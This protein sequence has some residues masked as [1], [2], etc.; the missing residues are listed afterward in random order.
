M[1]LFVSSAFAIVIVTL[2][3]PVNGRTFVGLAVPVPLCVAFT[4]SFKA[5][6]EPFALSVSEVF[7]TSVVFSNCPIAPMLC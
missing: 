5:D 3:T 1:M 6:T 4:Y 2:F 7:F